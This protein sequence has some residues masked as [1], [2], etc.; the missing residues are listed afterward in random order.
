LQAVRFVIDYNAA[1]G[2]AT[3]DD[4]VAPATPAAEVTVAVAGVA[5]VDDATAAVDGGGK[6]DAG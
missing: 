1:R 4:E 5:I 6:G 3:G 2:A